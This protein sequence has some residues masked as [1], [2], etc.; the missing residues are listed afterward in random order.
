VVKKGK[1]AFLISLFFRAIKCD[2]V[3]VIYVPQYESLK[4]EA[5]LEFSMTHKV[6]VDSLPPIREIWKMPRTYVC[7]VIFTR[8]RDVFQKWVN[9]RCH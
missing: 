6:V 9:E 4:L 3:K 5:I 2:D 1:T 7:N 8:L